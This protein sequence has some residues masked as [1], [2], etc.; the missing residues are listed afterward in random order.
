MYV[1]ETRTSRE[2]HVDDARPERPHW[3]TV[4]LR[5]MTP[6]ELKRAKQTWE[7]YKGFNDHDRHYRVVDWPEA[8]RWVRDGG[9][10]ETPLYVDQGRIRYA[11]DV[12]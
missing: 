11:R 4:T 7:A 6:A 5:E 12:S 2:R 3:S 8:H 1:F 10:H 9:H